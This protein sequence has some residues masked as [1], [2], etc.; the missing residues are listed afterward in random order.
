MYAFRVMEFV[1]L[2]A[3]SRRIKRNKSN[4]QTIRRGS[5]MNPPVTRA[6]AGSV[7]TAARLL[8]LSPPS[9]NQAHFDRRPAGGGSL[10]PPRQCLVQVSG[11]QHPKTAYVLLGLQ[12]RPVGEEHLA[13]GLRPQR[14]RA[15]GC[16][17]ASNE[18]P[19]TG[20][21]HLAVER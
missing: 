14:L 9:E 6:V 2:L 3:V 18:N 1:T 7:V 17:E 5:R 8:P 15:A 20:R 13:V 16:G 12:V 11:F 10:A 21:Y 4:A 19:D